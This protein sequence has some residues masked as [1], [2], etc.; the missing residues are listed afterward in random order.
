MVQLEPD[1]H[2]LSWA[3]AAR[4][5]AELGLGDQRQGEAGKGYA[6]ACYVGPGPRVD[7]GV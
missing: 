4:R 7:G 6:R 2:C 5:G 1:V 3:S